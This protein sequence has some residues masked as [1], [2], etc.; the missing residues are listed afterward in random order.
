MAVKPILVLLLGCFELF[1]VDG[2]K[3]FDHVYQANE[4]FIEGA[5]SVQAA[6]PSQEDWLSQH[7]KYSVFCGKDTVKVVMPTDTLSEVKVLGMYT[8][9]RVFILSCPLWAVLVAH[10]LIFFLLFVRVLNSRPSSRGS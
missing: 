2:F 8:G 9:A 6:V 5:L 1:I 3:I 10:V 7:Q 4:H